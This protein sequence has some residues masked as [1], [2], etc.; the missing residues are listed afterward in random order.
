ME[1]VLFFSCY[2][3]SAELVS[4]RTNKLRDE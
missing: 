3:L 1:D 2:L 4:W